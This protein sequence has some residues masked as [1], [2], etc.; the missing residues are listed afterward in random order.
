MKDT[1]KQIANEAVQTATE[2]LTKATNDISE[3]QEALGYKDGTYINV[4][5]LSSTVGEYKSKTDENSNNLSEV[6]T[7]YS[8]LEQT[9][10]NFETRVGNVESSVS[11]K[12]DNET[13]LSLTNRVS[14]VEQ[15]AEKISANVTQLTSD[16]STKAN[17]DDIPDVSGFLTKNDADNTYATIAQLETSTLTMESD[18]ATLANVQTNFDDLAEGFVSVNSKISYFGNAAGKYMMNS[19]DHYINSDGYLIYITPSTYTDALDDSGNYDST[20]VSAVYSKDGTTF[21]IKK[22]D[23]D[24]NGNTLETYSYEESATYSSSNTK[25]LGT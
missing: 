9:V 20:K 10:N 25:F 14:D 12:A 22:Y 11:K 24:E 15:S 19:D 23:E 3:I 6:S 13:V 5:D 21:Y 7:K 8:T 4:S 18:H 17:A 16:L 1:A 2:S